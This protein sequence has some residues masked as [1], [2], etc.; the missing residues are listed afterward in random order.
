MRCVAA[1]SSLAYVIKTIKNGVCN[2]KKGFSVGLRGSSGSER[3]SAA[4]EQVLVQERRRRE[5]RR[6]R[7]WKRQRK[8]GWRRWGFP[9][10]LVL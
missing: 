9:F 3:P 5:R 2:P 10:G 8:S 4:A 1:A 6:G 7:G